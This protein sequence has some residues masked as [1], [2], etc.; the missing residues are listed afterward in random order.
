[1]KGNFDKIFII[2]L[3]YNSILL[4][5]IFILIYGPDF[6]GPVGDTFGGIFSP[7]VGAISIY[8]I[9]KTFGAQREQL[10]D[11]KRANKIQRFH[12]EEQRKQYYVDRITEILYLQHE[13]INESIK[14]QTFLFTNNGKR[15]GVQGYAGLFS[16][17]ETIDQMLVFPELN[18]AEVPEELNKFIVNNI[19]QLIE[20]YENIFTAGTIVEKLIKDSKINSEK[21]YDDLK[22]LL[23]LNLGDIIKNNIIQIKKYM[24]V[25]KRNSS[26]LDV[27]Y[28]N[29]KLIQKLDSL[30][31]G[32]YTF[33][34]NI[35]DSAEAI[36]DPAK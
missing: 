33:F 36:Q 18:S 28:Q 21:S 8:F 14:S 31:A 13:R 12:L 22:I 15:E 4:I 1:M 10:E 19:I 11:Q 27:I 9:Y 25:H 23:A 26:D 16:L 2:S 32:A 7:I 30:V 5:L 34:E 3:L 35:L 24:D 17:N 20:I 29:E 6:T